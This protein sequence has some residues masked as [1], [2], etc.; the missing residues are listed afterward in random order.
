MNEKKIEKVKNKTKL[1][2]QVLQEKRTPARTVTR[3]CGYETSKLRIIG[4][5]YFKK[6]WVVGWHEPKLSG[7]SISIR[8]ADQ[9]A[10]KV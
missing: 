3:T 5:N 2:R 4:K 1:S 9:R 8:I 10:Q 6:C 7:S